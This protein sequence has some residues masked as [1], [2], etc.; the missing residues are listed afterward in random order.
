[1]TATA[2]SRGT[3]NGALTFVPTASA[4]AEAA[5]HH[6]HVFHPLS[7]GSRRNTT[8]AT[9]KDATTRSFC[10]VE[11]WSASTGRVAARRPPNRASAR[12][13]PI[14]LATPITPSTSA[15]KATVWGRPT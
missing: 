4:V 7:P 10:A 2:S 9:T 6:D 12:P 1:M 14:R 13:S 8:A 3:A 15:P 5:N 11:A